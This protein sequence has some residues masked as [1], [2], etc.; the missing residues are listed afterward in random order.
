[1]NFIVIDDERQ[2]ADLIGSLIKI[3]GH[4]ADVHYGR[5]TA[6]K[7]FIAK[8]NYYHGIIVDVFLDPGLGTDL[9]EEFRE[10][11]PGLPALVIS[12]IADPYNIEQLERYGQYLCKPFFPQ[13]FFD[14]FGE[15]EAAAG[16]LKNG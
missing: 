1:M 14:V 11:H 10:S 16:T 5:G 9:I 2:A 3:Q 12:G 15:L 13:A 6:K 8:P 7:A 4:S